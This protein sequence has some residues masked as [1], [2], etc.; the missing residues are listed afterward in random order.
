MDKFVTAGIWITRRCNFRC[1]YCN[2]PK[3]DFEELEISEWIDAVDIIK[4]LGVKKIVLL[5]GEVTLYKDLVKMVDYILN[6]SKLE[7]ALTTN[8]F[9]NYEIVKKL[10]KTGL[11]NIAVSIDTF[12]LTKSI[13]QIKSE[14]SIELIKKLEEDGLI[15]SINLKCYTVVS[16]NNINELED[17]IKNMTKRR[18]NIYLIPYH[19]GNEGHFEH[20]K[21]MDKFAFA[22]EEDIENYK[23]VIDKIIILKKK[24]YLV[25]NSEEY[26][27]ETK[28]HIKKLSWRCEGLS[29][30]RVD[31]DGSLLCCCDK[32]GKVNNNFSI[33]DLGDEDKIKDFLKMRSEDS[34]PCSGCLWPSSFESERIKNKK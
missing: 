21:N 34:E 16:K 20:R 26:L 22:T 19:W 27:L 8:A 10:I 25:D 28:K 6:S 17:F 14:S 12:N 13:S 33:F 5:G 7:C 9:K 3:T 32:K 30:L 2:V 4:K 15:N 29:E 24:G 18:I 23:K 11:K 31:S 1:S